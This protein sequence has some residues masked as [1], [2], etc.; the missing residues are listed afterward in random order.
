MNSKTYL[1]NTDYNEMIMSISCDVSPS[2]YYLLFQPK[3]D[4]KLDSF[5]E[6]IVG[7]GRK[8]EWDSI[9]IH[10]TNDDILDTL[11]NKVIQIDNETGF[12]DY[13]HELLINANTVVKFSDKLNTLFHNI[14]E[15]YFI[16]Y[17]EEVLLNTSI[18]DWMAGT[19][20][21]K[22]TILFENGVKLDK[23]SR[24]ICNL[25]NMYDN[26]KW[27]ESFYKAITPR[28]VNDIQRFT[29]LIRSEKKVLPP[30]ILIDIVLKCIYSFDVAANM[31]ETLYDLIPKDYPDGYKER[32]TEIKKIV[33]N[34]KILQKYSIIYTVPTYQL[35][36]SHMEEVINAMVAFIIKKSNSDLD[37]FE[38]LYKDL[39][40]FDKLQSAKQ[41]FINLLVETDLLE[42][43]S[44]FMKRLPEE[45]V[46][47]IVLSIIKNFILKSTSL[48]DKLL[49]KAEKLI[50]T[51]N[52]ECEEI[53]SMNN[54]LKIIEFASKLQLSI[55]PSY[56]LLE[57]N[58]R[59]ILKRIFEVNP[60]LY[61]NS[62]D[63]YPGESVYLFAELLNLNSK[64]DNSKITLK[65]LEN[66]WKDR[67]LKMAEHFCL[68]LLSCD[69]CEDEKEKIA[70]ICRELYNEHG[71]SPESKKMFLDY[72]IFHI[73]VE[74][75]DKVLENN[76]KLRFTKEPNYYLK[77]YM[78]II[79]NEDINKFTN[80]DSHIDKLN[81]VYL[82]CTKLSSSILLQNKRVILSFQR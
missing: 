51:V 49:I 57:R 31:L 33:R 43:S 54:T 9:K 59:N 60:N 46:L 56:L 15:L 77:S 17:N 74:N 53:I 18:S 71:I 13:C 79:L 68:K 28:T 34:L 45:I 82:A 3:N 29:T 76:T 35:I 50:D 24:I 12:I 65:L 2:N 62:N 26:N 1:I 55:T 63:K 16:L 48:S 11:F 70:E 73:S 36:N 72:S 41:I 58:G 39:C 61:I 42:F 5:E 67:D 75:L 25:N 40:I 78:N 44:T 52:M 30:D 69:L 8:I 6:Y 66:S 23:M 64:E 21:N 4:L 47:S 32:I 38:E 27:I 81:N 7:Y 22:C 10:I 80:V 19:E 14:K 20:E 37:A